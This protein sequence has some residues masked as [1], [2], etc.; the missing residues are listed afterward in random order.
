M[1]CIPKLIL[2]TLIVRY[3]LPLSLFASS[4]WAST[5]WERGVIIGNR[6]LRFPLLQLAWYSCMA[7]D[8]C[9]RK[10]TVYS[11]RMSSQ[12]DY[13]FDH[14]SSVAD[15]KM[16]PVGLGTDAQIPH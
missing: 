6:V 7:A 16:L 3:L 11:A 14:N 5:F 8:S 15:Q 1:E 9:T 10:D 4:E 13:H 12:W 2:L